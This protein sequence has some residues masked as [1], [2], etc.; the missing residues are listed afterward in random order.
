MKRFFFHLRRDDGDV[1]PDEQGTECPDLEFAVRE[2]CSG[3]REILAEAIR[4]NQQIV[5]DEMLVAD[6]EGRTLETIP[7]VRTTSDVD[8]GQAAL[9]R[10]CV[11]R[12]TLGHPTGSSE[13]AGREFLPPGLGAD[14]AL[15]V[16]RPF[17]EHVKSFRN[18]RRPRSPGPVRSRN[19]TRSPLSS[20]RS[21]PNSSRCR[22]RISALPAAFLR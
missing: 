1:L 16:A 22:C 13:P 15:Q 11:P 7:L 5:A 17:P 21:P 18:R 9:T 6:E 10:R 3:A 2:A 20:A 19:N 8:K 4:H 12:L 14:H